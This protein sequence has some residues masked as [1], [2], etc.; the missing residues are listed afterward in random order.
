[1]RHKFKRWAGLCPASIDMDIGR[2]RY[3][4][5]RSKTGQVV[6]QSSLNCLD[7]TLKLA[8]FT[9]HGEEVRVIIPNYGCPRGQK[10][11]RRLVNCVHPLSS[12]LL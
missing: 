5:K 2:E 7:L 1:M 9:W 4:N 8:A 11:K 6:H 3:S 12:V 10:C